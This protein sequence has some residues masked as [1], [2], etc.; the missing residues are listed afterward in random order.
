MGISIVG[1][2][3]RP[4]RDLFADDADEALTYDS[5]PICSYV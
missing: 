1:N 4:Q 5:T 2:V 3:P